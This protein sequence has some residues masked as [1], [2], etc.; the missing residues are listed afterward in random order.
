MPSEPSHTIR[1]TINRSSHLHF[2]TPIWSPG[3]VRLIVRWTPSTTNRVH[4]S[5]GHSGS[6]AVSSRSL[7]TTSTLQ[8]VLAATLLPRHRTSATFYSIFPSLTVSSGGSIMRSPHSTSSVTAL[9]PGYVQSIP[10]AQMKT[11]ATPNH[12]LQRTAPGVTACAPTRRPAPAAFPH[13]LRRPPQSLSLG[14]LGVSAR[15]P[16]NESQR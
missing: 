11:A 10:R 16:S 12:A 15:V 5:I 2:R 1:E 9:H 14:S 7:L 6:R 8:R 13:R 4:V 3:L